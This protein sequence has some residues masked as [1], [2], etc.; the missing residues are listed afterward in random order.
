MLVHGPSFSGYNLQR[1]KAEGGTTIPG[2]VYLDMLAEI[3]L[4]LFLG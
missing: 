1:V 4:H 2:E 3:F